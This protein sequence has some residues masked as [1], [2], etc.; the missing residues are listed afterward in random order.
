MDD[1]YNPPK[2]K[3]KSQG[4]LLMEITAIT[5]EYPQGNLPRL[6]PSQSYAKKVVSNLANDKLIKQISSGGLKGYRLTIKGKRS[7]LSDNPA[8]FAGFLEGVAETNK[9]RSGYERRLRLHSLAEVCTL[10]NGAGV[11]IFADVKPKVFLSNEMIK[12]RMETETTN[13]INLANRTEPR[14]VDAG[15]KTLANPSQPSSESSEGNKLPKVN[16]STSK[17]NPHQ[18]PPVDI[19]TPYFYLS[20]EQKGR[21]DN[22]IR[23]SRAAGTLL[24]PTH[25]YS[26][27]NTGNAESYWSEKIEQ[28][29]KAEVQDYICRKLLFHQYQGGA[30]NGIMIGA[31]MEILEKYLIINKK[32][33]DTQKDAQRT[34]PQNVYHF[35]TK[36]FQSFYYITNDKQGEAQLK[37][38]CDN[39]K[40]VSLKNVLTKGLHPPDIKHPIEHDALTE[41]GNPVL[42]CCLL[43][44]PRLIRF[45]NG[46]ALHGKVG[47]VIAFDFQL[48]VLGRYLGN[49][50]EFTDIS[51]DK[52]AQRFLH[53]GL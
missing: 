33:Q 6:I 46:V 10:M 40:M 51:F 28:R 47:R 41:G 52:F 7:L 4:R 22:A 26:I 44:I 1:G 23:G 53:S 29:F 39:N 8:R 12:S 27:Y 11:E 31:D 35:L 45:R 32:R 3:P 34:K 19:T 36:V 21:D 30:V 16:S 25:V 13:H 50:A 15:L 38:L 20:R 49:T 24:T 9:M 42:F 48:E 43:D 5:G 14:C 2:T 37:L 17:G 18:Y